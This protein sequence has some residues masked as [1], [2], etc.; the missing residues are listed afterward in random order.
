MFIFRHSNFM[1]ICKRKIKENK[2]KKDTKK[3]SNIK[4]Y[5]LILENLYEDPKKLFEELS[6]T[7]KK[8]EPENFLSENFDFFTDFLTSL[9]FIRDKKYLNLIEIYLLNFQNLLEFFTEE[10]INFRNIY[11]E[12][13]IIL[14]RKFKQYDLILDL[15]KFFKTKNQNQNQNQK[16]LTYYDTTTTDL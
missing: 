1:A 13:F 9:K 2:G 7:S 5:S 15:L 14:L 3:S 12:N 8:F 10:I 16:N 6:S 11:N 4:N